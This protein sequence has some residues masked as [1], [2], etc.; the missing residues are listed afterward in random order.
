MSEARL[1]RSSEPR[2]LLV[3]TNNPAQS[4]RSANRTEG[5]STIKDNADEAI[6]VGTP[7]T[8]ID[9]YIRDFISIYKAATPRQRHQ[10]MSAVYDFEEKVLN[11]D[12]D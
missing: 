3:K 10:L 11:N 12:G 8:R 5:A 6:F 7:P 9:E 1:K 4:E 2:K